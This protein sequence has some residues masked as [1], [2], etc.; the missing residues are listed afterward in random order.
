[1]QLGEV[2][3]IETAHDFYFFIESIGLG[4][5]VARGAKVFGNDL[6]SVEL[7]VFEALGEEYL[8][9]LET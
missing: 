2:R 6:G 3:V 9:S 7:L 8:W 4:I 1:M 5:F